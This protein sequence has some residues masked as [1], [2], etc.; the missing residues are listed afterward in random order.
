MHLNWIRDH[1]NVSQL[2]HFRAVA[3]RTHD[4]RYGASSLMS[5]AFGLPHPVTRS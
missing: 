3:G 4:A 2:I 1:V 5:P